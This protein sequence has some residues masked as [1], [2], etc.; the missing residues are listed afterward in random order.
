[1]Q[2]PANETAAAF[3]PDGHWLVYQSTETGRSEIYVQPFPGPARST[4][5]STGGGTAPF[6][7]ADSKEIFYKSLD[8][9]V[10]AISIS[11][12]SGSVEPGVPVELFTVRPTATFNAARDGQRFLVN[13]PTGDETTPP[14]TVVLNWK[15]RQ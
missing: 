13:T 12:N 7:R 3:S 15:P 1:V 8:N 9:R 6:W 11:M 2:T 10:M 14:I 5:L 4:L